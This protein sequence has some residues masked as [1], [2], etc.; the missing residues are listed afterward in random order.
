MENQK[1]WSTLEDS[2]WYDFVR[3]LLKYSADIASKILS[4]E[5]V[6]VHDIE[7]TDF[8]TQLC[9][10]AELMIDPYYR[11]I[12][13]FIILIEKEWLSFGFQFGIRKG[14]YLK[15]Q[16]DDQKSPIFLLWL[17]CVH[18]LV[19]QFPNAFEFN[20]E[21]LLF[22]AQTSNSNL[23]GTFLFNNE[24]ERKNMDAEI[25][26]ASVWSDVLSSLPRFRNLFYSQENITEILTPNYAPYNLK[27]WDDFFMFN[28]AYVK[29]D[30]F[31]LDED[32]KV[33]FKSQ[34]EFFDWQKSQDEEKFENIH[35]EIGF[36]AT[37]LEEILS[38]T[39]GSEAYD[40]FSDSTKRYFEAA[41]N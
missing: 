33:S 38:L 26:T 41:K 40:S 21:F 15:D 10:L 3:K 2:D 25:N 24:N 19:Y 14:I 39:K 11:T 5:M 36:I 29:N 13:G 9:A 1:F 23:Y 6:L 18:Q 12:R 27:F 4:N 17:D 37:C 35:N 8:T 31:Y 22:L 20:N 28:S 32:K 16:K 7:G 30:S 34:Q